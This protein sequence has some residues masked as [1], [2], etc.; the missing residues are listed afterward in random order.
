VVEPGAVVVPLLLASGYHV[1]VDLPAQAP[2]AV[3]TA[4]VGPDP[5]LADALAD[6]LS[7]AGYDGESSVVLAAAGST[8]DNALTEVRLMAARLA[9]RLGVEVEPAFVSAGT[10]RLRD[11]TPE[12]VAAYLLAPGAFYDAV[13]T[14]HARVVSPPIGAHSAVAEIVLDRYDACQVPGRTAPA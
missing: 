13:F 14:T 7:E 9:A 4:A 5:L 2:D 12:V 1:R 8:D 11:T 6:R 3:V 10:P